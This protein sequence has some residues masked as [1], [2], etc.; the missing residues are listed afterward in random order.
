MAVDTTSFSPNPSVFPYS[1]VSEL[2]QHRSDFPRSEIEFITLN[3]AI[4]LT[5]VG[6]SSFVVYAAV[7]PANFSY[8]LTDFF[9][10]IHSAAAATNN[11]NAALT[12]FV[13]DDVLGVVRSYEIFL[14]NE[15]TNAKFG[16]TQIDTR[17]YCIT[18]FPTQLLRSP[19]GGAIELSAQA[20][21]ETTND[22]AYTTDFY[23]RFQQFDV[24]Q[25]HDAAV[26]RQTPVRTR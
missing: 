19:G 25:A 5:G 9:L 1:G 14:P 3:G 18:C 26:N 24:N 13:N 21:N 22:T 12:L 20:T 17:T 23:C 7:L 2:L 8:V 4:P 16:S 6:D 11:F 10:A 15:S